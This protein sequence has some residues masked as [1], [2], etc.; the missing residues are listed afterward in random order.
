MSE[1]LDLSKQQF[2]ELTCLRP[3]EVNRYGYRWLCRCDCGRLA[4]RLAAQLRYAIKC[5]HTPAC[6]I[7]QAEKWRGFVIDR[8]ER[9]RERLL[10]RWLLEG[11]LYSDLWEVSEMAAL[12]SEFGVLDE[13]EPDSLDIADA[14]QLDWSLMPFYGLEKSSKEKPKFSVHSPSSFDGHDVYYNQSIMWCATCGH[15]W[16]LNLEVARKIS[17]QLYAPGSQKLSIWP[18]G[19]AAQEQPVP[20]RTAPLAAKA[21]RPRRSFVSLLDPPDPVERWHA[22]G[23]GNPEFQHRVQDGDPWQPS[24]ILR[25]FRPGLTHFMPVHT[26]S[27]IERSA[28]TGMSQRYDLFR[29]DEWNAGAREPSVWSQQKTFISGVQ[30]VNRLTHEHGWTGWSLR[31][32]E[33]GESK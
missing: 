30:L 29:R 26:V 15:T 18:Q 31:I 25:L 23:S 3:V 13:T 24:H 28:Y 4:I 9:R 16:P 10:I 21:P 22:T 20:A 33:S 11:S 12:R 32:C 17:A 2:G 27:V 19:H 7:C 14:G 1:A 8:R 6:T 5:G